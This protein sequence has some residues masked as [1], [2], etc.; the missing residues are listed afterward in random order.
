V[1]QY[2]TGRLVEKTP[3]SVVLDVGGVGYHLL[4]SV[5]THEAL[6]PLGQ[7]VTVLTHFVVREDAHILYGFFQE[8]ERSL[9]RLLMSVTG[10][11]PKMAITILSGL[12]VPELKRAIVEGSLHVLSGISGVGRKTA[13]RIV[14]EL[15]EKVVL[16]ERREGLPLTVPSNAQDQLVE[17]SLRALIQL[18]Y[19]KQNAK[20]AVQKALKNAPAGKHSVEELIRESLKHV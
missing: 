14:V 9:F 1:Y 18:G 12:T 17:D 7:S 11:G 2:L 16:E 19:R 13:E 8:E 4:I 20:E 10:I 3:A 15:R 5:S 6:P